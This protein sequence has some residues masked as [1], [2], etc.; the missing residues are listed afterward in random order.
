M[1][2]K[3]FSDRT[4]RKRWDFAGGHCEYCKLPIPFGK[5]E[6]HHEKEAESGGDNSFENCRVLCR[7][8]HMVE[9]A[10]FKRECAKADRQ[11]ARYVGARKHRAEPQRRATGRVNKWYGVREP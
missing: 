9:T 11:K 6:Y 1:S 7:V 4:C 8:C 10:R 5:E 3:E 2:R